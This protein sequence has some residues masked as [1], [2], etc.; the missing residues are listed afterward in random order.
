[1]VRCTNRTRR[2]ALVAAVLALGTPA[3][4]SGPDLSADYGQTAREN[5]I[6]ALDEFADKDWEEAIAY[7]DFVRIRFPFSRY[8]VE[9]ELLIARAE[10]EQG[11]YVTAR[12]AFKQFAKLH[13]TH[14]HAR[15][16][17]AAYMAAASAYMNA[18]TDMFL[19]PKAAERDQTPL[20]EALEDLE[21]YFANYAGTITEK[22][23]RKLR[24]EVY[25]RLL[26][27]ELYVAKYYLD[28]D[29]PRAAIGRLEAAGKRY[30][31]VGMTADVLF[32]LGVT[33]LRIGQVETAR[34]TFSRLA[35]RFPS[36]HHG[37]QARIYLE[38]I[39]KTHGPATPGKKDPPLE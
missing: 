39:R 2:A 24:D 13:P 25:R 34:A 30:P 16:G 7:A 38:Y 1:M 14:R 35:A 4:K 37:K 11:N 5:F 26:E 3:C 21:Y 27:H 20:H 18:P 22:Y 12:D 6:L 15:N 29:K 23:A 31:D 9:A 28:R 8:A 33:Q 19:L 36:H 10:F 17:W 32:L